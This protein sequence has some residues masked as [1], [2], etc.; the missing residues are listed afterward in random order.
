M[1]RCQPEIQCSNFVVRIYKKE[2]AIKRRFKLIFTTEIYLLE[3]RAGNRPV[4]FFQDKQVGFHRLQYKCLD[5]QELLSSLQRIQNQ[6]ADGNSF[7]E[8]ESVS[9]VLWHFAFFSGM[10][11]DLAQRP[12]IFSLKLYFFHYSNL[13]QSKI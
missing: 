11:Y 12:S 4:T 9:L 13:I 7:P 3:N 8:L 2:N 1:T 10:Y 5:D 6:N